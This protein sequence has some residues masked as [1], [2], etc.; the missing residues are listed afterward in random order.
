MVFGVKKMFKVCSSGLNLGFAVKIV[1]REDK[2]G[3]FIRRVVFGA[4]A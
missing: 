3:G 4:A 2:W 1:E